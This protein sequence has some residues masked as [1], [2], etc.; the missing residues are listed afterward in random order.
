MEDVTIKLKNR[1][2]LSNL[3]F[4]CLKNSDDLIHRLESIPKL[5][6]V[7]ITNTWLITFDFESL[8]TNITRKYVMYMLNTALKYHFLTQKEYHA[9]SQLYNFMQDNT[10]FHIGHEK[11]YRQINGLTM[12]SYDAQNTSN[13]VLLFHELDLLKHPLIQKFV[14]CYSRYIDDG[15]CIIQ[16]DIYIVHEIRKIISTILPTEIPIEFCIRKFRNNF[17]DLW[18]TLDNNTF[19]DGKL[20][21]HI[22]Q[23]EFNTYSYIHR[24][25]NHPRY[26]FH[27]IIKTEH[28]RYKRK[29]SSYL[30]RS[31]I[32]KLF[33][34]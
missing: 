16:G 27:G 20:A 15:F 33:T 29:S 28:I 1:F 4:P 8:Y 19:K 22:Y 32:Q 7:D 6:L 26:I 12:G 3:T 14:K 17:L 31:H 13:N 30:E 10:F 24:N 9:C 34:I 11:F 5:N 25:S 21:Y 18:I 2:D 23:K